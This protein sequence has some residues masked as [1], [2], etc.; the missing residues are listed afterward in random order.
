MC[1]ELNL[2]LGLLRPTAVPDGLW[3][4]WKPASKGMPLLGSLFTGEAM[5]DGLLFALM[6]FR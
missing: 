6:A 5:L 4:I 1:M 3:P 2:I